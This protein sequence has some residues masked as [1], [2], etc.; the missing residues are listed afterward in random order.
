ML[1]QVDLSQ[2]SMFYLNIKKNIIL[3]NKLSHFIFLEVAPVVFEPLNLTKLY[4]V[5]PL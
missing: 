5:N 3:K 4:Q 1:T 2:Y